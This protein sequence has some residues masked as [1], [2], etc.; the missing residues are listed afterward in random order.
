[1]EQNII[2]EILEIIENALNLEPNSLTVD[3]SSDD[4]EEWDSLGHLGIL[5]SLNDYY[6]GGIADI[7]EMANANSVR[8]ILQLLKDFSLI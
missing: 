3:S 7:E 8:K 4:V 1:M 2:D 5:A 6:K